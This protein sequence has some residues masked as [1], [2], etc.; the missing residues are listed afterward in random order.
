[1]ETKQDKIQDNKSPLKIKKMLKSNK[2]AKIIKLSIFWTY[3]QMIQ[4]L[5]KK[6]LYVLKG[7]T[8]M[9]KLNVLYPCYMSF[10]MTNSNIMLTLV[11]M[12]NNSLVNQALFD[13]TILKSDLLLLVMILRR[14][15]LKLP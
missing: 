2:E 9:V 8:K 11:L 10:K 3:L 15:S 7:N 1:M 6:I 4:S 5:R 12:A 14:E 13:F